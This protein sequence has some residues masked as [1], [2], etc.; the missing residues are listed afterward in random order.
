MAAARVYPIHSIVKRSSLCV[1]NSPYCT[2]SLPASP[3]ASCSHWRSQMPFSDVLKTP[4]RPQIQIQQQQQQPRLK[5]RQLLP[6]RYILARC[7]FVHFA[8]PLPNI[9]S[10]TTAGRRTNLH[11]KV[12][13]LSHWQDT[14]FYRSALV[15]LQSS[16]KKQPLIGGWLLLKN[17]RFLNHC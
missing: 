6:A 14:N 4:V 10:Y 3:L 7:A 1:E 16:T 13:V 12:N 15:A 2:P 9:N 11:A 17:Q 8:Q 5:E